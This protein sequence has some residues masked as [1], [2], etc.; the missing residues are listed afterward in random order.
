MH[1]KLWQSYSEQA[2]DFI[3]G[4]LKADSQQ[5]NTIDQVFAH[6][7]M[8]SDSQ[9][10]DGCV[11]KQVLSNMR[12][13]SHSNPVFSICAASVAKQLD[14]RSLQD[15]QNV[16]SDM[17]TNGDG[18]LELREV[19]T[20]FEKIFGGS[21]EVLKDIEEMFKRL[22][23]DGSGRI[24]YTEFCA[25]GLGVGGPT[26]DLNDGISEE[27]LRAAFKAFDVNDDNGRISREEIM[28][29]LASVD[30]G[31]VWSKEVCEAVAEE[32]FEKFDADKDGSLDFD[33]WMR[34]MRDPGLRFSG[35]PVNREH[36]DVSGPAPTTTAP[37]ETEGKVILHAKSA[38]DVGR[39]ETRTPSLMAHALSERRAQFGSRSGSWKGSGDGESLGRG[40]RLFEKVTDI[41]SMSTRSS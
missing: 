27:A 29:V 40:R 22:D 32:I 13:F 26:S 39:R 6:P 7:W 1:D 17:D 20:G 35:S 12:N 31:Q 5:R 34:L 30:V 9:H 24:D 25:A 21:S 14:Y 37:F 16:F 36:R 11:A 38:D 19:R 4:L 33:E 28:R 3:R 8:Q 23:L 41:L 10:A 18:V 15:L 2:K